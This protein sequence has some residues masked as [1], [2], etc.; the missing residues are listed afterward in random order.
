VSCAIDDTAFGPK[1]AARLISSE[2]PYFARAAANNV[3]GG[4]PWFVLVG[5][6]LLLSPEGQHSSQALL[7]LDAAAPK[8][9]SLAWWPGTTTP[10]R[11][12][13]KAGSSGTPHASGRRL[14]LT[15]FGRS[16]S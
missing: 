1:L 6:R 7:L 3:D 4:N 15:R 12:P 9:L 8:I 13:D 16:T 2:N 5:D 11:M 10:Q 14:F